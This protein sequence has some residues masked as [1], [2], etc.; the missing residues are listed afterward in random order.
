MRTAR[1][2]LAAVLIV[3]DAAAQSTSAEQQGGAVPELVYPAYYGESHALRDIEPIAPED[4]PPPEMPRLHYAPPAETIPL[5]L[6]SAPPE[7]PADAPSAVLSLVPGFNFDGIG[8]GVG[9][10][11]PTFVPPDPNGAVGAFQYVQTVNSSFAIYRK[12]SASSTPEY[13]PA[14]LN[15]G[16]NTGGLCQTQSGLDPVVLYD[17]L[18]NRWVISR[19]VVD[20]YSVPQRFL[21][22]VAVSTSAD[23]A[24]PYRYF[25]Y[26][27]PRLN[28][29][30]KLGG[31]PSGYFLSF[32]MFDCPLVN[33]VPQCVYAKPRL[34]ALDRAAMLSPQL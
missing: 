14:A 33:G 24:G 16:W 21:E 15:T 25:A 10:F 11:T 2:F 28:D 32:N 22:C 5:L 4:A 8:F 29:Y 3:S 13:G 7:E 17:K 19:L 12:S 1:T 20:F 34:C 9:G 6:D 23:A 26:A 30:G 27:M 31:W 18:A